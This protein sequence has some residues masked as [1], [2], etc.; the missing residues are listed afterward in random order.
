LLYTTFHL[1]T[2][3]PLRHKGRDWAKGH[4]HSSSPQPVPGTPG[5]RQSK[6]EGHE[7]REKA[8]YRAPLSSSPSMPQSQSPS[9]RG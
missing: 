4:S 3:P 5:S 1:A 2:S 8:T 7:A 6:G 9:E